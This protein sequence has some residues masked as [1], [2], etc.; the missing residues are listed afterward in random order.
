MNFFIKQL[1]DIHTYRAVFVTVRAGMPYRYLFG[2]KIKKNKKIFYN[3]RGTIM[4]LKRQ[5]VI[6]KN[7]GISNLGK[8]T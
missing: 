2:Q 3:F 6:G 7:A 5:G 8:N 1:T 4:R